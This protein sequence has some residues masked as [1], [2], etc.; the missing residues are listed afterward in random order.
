MFERLKSVLTGHPA[1][2]APQLRNALTPF[3]AVSEALFERAVG[4]VHDGSGPEILLELDAAHQADLDQLMGRPG[5]LVSWRPALPEALKQRLLQAG[6]PGEPRVSVPRARAELYGT[7]AVTQ[8]EFLRFGY[9]LAALGTGPNRRVDGVPAWLTTLLNDLASVID[10]S[11]LPQLQWPPERFADLLRHDGCP[12]TEIPATVVLAMCQQEKVWGGNVVRPHEL[13]GI[14]NYLLGFGQLIPPARVGRLSADS[15]TALVQRVSDDPRL[16]GVLA[17][18]VAQLAADPA[19][20]V[21][22]AAV[23]VLPMLPEQLRAAVLAPVLVTV[24]AA[25]SGELIE[26]LSRTEAGGALLDEAVASGAKLGTA[27]RKANAR[28]DALASAATQVQQL[29]LPDF[30]PLPDE[31]DEARALVELRQSLDAQIARLVGVEHAWSVRRLK[32]LRQISDAD[33]RRIVEAARGRREPPEVLGRLHLGTIAQAVR[34]FDLV[35]LLRLRRPDKKARMV[36]SVQPRVDQVT[37][38]RQVEDAVRRTWNTRE[39]LDEVAQIA[40]PSNYWVTIDA[41]VVW[42]WAAQHLD[43]LQAWLAGSAQD[44]GDAL[45]ILDAFPSLPATLLPSIAA[46]A[47]GESRRNRPAAQAVLAKHGLARELAEQ[48]LTDGR[49]EIRAASAS[50]LAKATDPAAVPAVR[51]ALAKEKREVP[52]AAML[53]AL[54]DLGD[55]ISTDL[56]PDRLLAEAKKGLRAK[57]PAT[58][59]W[60]GFDQLP[61][62]RWADGSEVDPAIPTW[63]AV[64]ANKVKDP[65]GS[66]LLDLYLE[67]LAPGSAEALGRFVLDSWIAQDTRHPVEEE[68]R[69]FAETDGRRRYDWAQSNLK[70]VLGNPNQAQYVERLQQAAAVPLEQH[71][72]DAYAMHQG[73]YLGS[74]SANRG[75]LALTTRVPGIELADA[76]R[77]YI[78]NH[79]AR[80][81]QVDS[82]MYTL[83][84]NGQPAAVQ[85]LLSISRRFK[86]ASVQAT[87]STLVENLADRRGWTADELADRT[88]PAAGFDT[89]ALLRLDFGS[90]TFIGRATP[91]GTIELS[92]PDGRPI[93]SLPAARA[94]DDAELVK[95]AKKQLTASRKELKAVLTQQTARLYEAMCVGRTWTAGDWRE[96]L[97]EHPLVGQLVSRLVWLENPGPGQRAFRPTEDGSLIDADDDTVELAPDAHVGLAHR[98]SVSDDVAAAWQMHLADYEVAPLFAQ[99]DNAVPDLD[100]AATDSYDLQGHLTDTFSFR[101]VA[102]KRGY[103]RAAA[104]DGAWF[105]EY[106]KQFQ[107]AGLT[108]VLEFTGSYLPEENFACATMGLSFRDARRRSVRLADVP[109][110]L[111]AECYA[112]YAALAA[113]G[114]FDPDWGK[115]TGT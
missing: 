88:I 82:L 70:R 69:A 14:D 31:L 40:R 6:V 113:L 56:A 84:A 90:R 63:W 54:R 9:L 36:W 50:W 96:F 41:D 49:G 3:R 47:V 46:A 91:S 4:Y 21:R 94:A 72:R 13:P 5:V 37:D 109:D 65:D 30:T 42:P 83:Y 25:A 73:T 71:V 55:D 27:V 23:G 12:E 61:A 66:G 45:A 60:F 33:L 105:S 22:T 57:L 18:I 85:L 98:A 75:L 74:A 99:F 108:A 79:G 78:R 48:G 114:P 93:K 32:D 28:R 62:L 2:P 102:T 67:R 95:A 51:A 7:R 104:E 8:P 20:G 92:N 103:Q 106:T 19:K 15:R 26:Y 64:L 38:L 86:Q 39:A 77:A 16:A 80:R 107:A 52:R 81:A 34:S 17:P 76:V 115:K 43:V 100:R 59:D 58:L 29:V 44:A 87:A 53:N 11:A 24:P 101:G 68:S 10:K 111:L 89:D 97:F 110:V 112:D 1:G 35:H